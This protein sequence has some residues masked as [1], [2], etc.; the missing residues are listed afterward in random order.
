MGFFGSYPITKNG[1]L[2]TDMFPPKRRRAF[3]V[4]LAISPLLGP[5]V[6]LVTAGFLTDAECWR[7]IF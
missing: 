1:E 2:I 5:V 3:M 4:D 7:W 6:A